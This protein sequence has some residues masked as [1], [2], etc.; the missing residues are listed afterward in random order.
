MG[1][2]KLFLLVLITA[3][4]GVPLVAPPHRVAARQDS[5][6]APLR[7]ITLSGSMYIKDDEITFDESDTY[8]ISKEFILSEAFPQYTYTVE[9][10][11]GD[12]VVGVLS[13]LFVLEGDTVT[14]SGYAQLYEGTGCSTDDLEDSAQIAPF[15]VPP[16]GFHAL[17]IDL[18]NSGFGGGDKI[19][20]EVGITNNALPP[21]PN[22]QDTPQLREVAVSGTMWIKDDEW[23]LSDETGLYDV[24][25]DAVLS[26]QQRETTLAF[27]ECEGDEVVGVLDL[28][29]QLAPDNV[30]IIVGGRAQLYEGTDCSRGDLEDE[31]DIPAFVVRPNEAQPFQ[32]F[33][34]N[35]GFGGGDAIEIDVTV[36]NMGRE[37]PDRQQDSDCDGLSNAVEAYLAN[38]YKPLLIF[39]EDEPVDIHRQIAAVYQVTPVVRD[40][41]KRGA[42]ITYVYLYPR[43]DGP[44]RID[45]SGFEDVLSCEAVVNAVTFTTT[46]LLIP[47]GSF[48]ATEIAELSGIAA[49]YAAHDGDSEALR[50][51]VTAPDIDAG[52][53][54]A[55]DLDAILMKRHFDDWEIY[56]NF[57]EFLFAPANDMVNPSTLAPG[58]PDP[59]YTRP[60]IYVSASKHAMY[61]SKD[62]CE[63]YE[64]GISLAGIPT[65]CDIIFEKCDSNDPNDW[66]FVPMPPEHNVGEWHLH[67][68]DGM[69]GSGS[70][71]LNTLYPYSAVWTDQRFCGGASSTSDV[72]LPG[73]HACAGALH[74]KW[75]PPD[76]TLIAA[77]DGDADVRFTLG[78]QR[79]AADQ[80]YVIVDVTP[81]D[82]PSSDGNGVLEV[83]NYGG[84]GYSVYLAGNDQP[85]LSDY[86]G[87]V[88]GLPPGDY[89]I[90]SQ[91]TLVGVVTVQPGMQTTIELATGVLEVVNYGGQAY[92]IYPAGDPNIQLDF[93]Y[94]DARFG[95]PTGTYDIWTRGE[96][97]AVVDISRGQTT[98][99]TLDTGVLEVVNFGGQA[100]SIYPAGDPNIQ[101]DFGYGDARFGLV[102]GSYDVWTRGQLMGTFTVTQGQMTTATLDTGV[103]DVRNPSGEPYSIYPTGDPNTQID[104][105]YGDARFGL[106]RGTYDIWQSETLVAT[107]TV[108]TGE[109]T[110]I[111]LN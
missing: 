4:V 106:V 83:I 91:Y 43:D 73:Q 34:A 3:A 26:S 20:I 68:F 88:F 72:D 90:W 19:E 78:L 81:L 11:T 40:N 2:R 37:C 103:L 67:T 63:G 52:L 49:W 10:C 41:G 102:S 47:G 7:L 55:W 8:P 28:T 82:P 18:D 79:A 97:V 110:V 23:I 84:A 60:V 89:E 15:A 69:A 111:E 99:A 27:E 22:A 42:M 14:G 107:V 58:R 53:D 56:E 25:G 76:D 16:G 45:I 92:S 48:A 38:R 59:S 33:L 36:S 77:A 105:G 35:S 74:G 70:D 46:G 9:Q 64:E 6:P 62:E 87:G 86:S 109:V 57:N 85:V 30:S 50:L 66:A 71:V 96:L 21:A 1:L 5:P 94:G 65:T 17:D 93:G 44:Q 98:T 61:N 75:W 80:N 51:F 108:N 100:Y 101:L 12:E 39:D 29:L 31:L 95:L 24:T 13:I 54:A 32:L 104:F